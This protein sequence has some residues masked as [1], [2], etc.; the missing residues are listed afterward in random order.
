MHPEKNMAGFPFNHPGKAHHAVPGFLSGR[1]DGLRHPHPGDKNAPPVFIEGRL[2]RIEVHAVIDILKSVGKFHRTGVCVE[3]GRRAKRVMLIS[4][5]GLSDTHRR[6][7]ENIRISEREKVGTFHDPAEAFVA[8]L[9]RVFPPLSVL[10]AEEKDTS[11][12][13]AAGAAENHITASVFLKD[14]RVSCI[15]RVADIFIP[16]NRDDLFLGVPVVE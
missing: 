2:W 8:V 12:L 5:S 11:R 13:P 7:D 6:T 9:G 10:A 3:R 14:L 15:D 16:E 4:F 1:I